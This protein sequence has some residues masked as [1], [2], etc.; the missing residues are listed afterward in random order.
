[1]RP[2][3]ALAAVCLSLFAFLIALAAMARPWEIARGLK[4]MRRD[5]LSTGQAAPDFSLKTKD[6]RK[7]VELSSFKNKRPVVLIFGSYT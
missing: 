7:T 2:Q 4:H 6:G 3:L 1:M 5:R